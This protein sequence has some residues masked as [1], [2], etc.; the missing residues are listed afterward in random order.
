MICSQMVACD[1]ALDGCPEWFHIECIEL[2]DLPPEEQEKW[3]C[4]SCVKIKLGIV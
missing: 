3:F 4:N 2:D 1:L